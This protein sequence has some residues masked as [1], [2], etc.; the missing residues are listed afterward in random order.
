[1]DTRSKDDIKDEEYTAFYK[2]I[3]KDSKEPLKWV[4][5]KAEGE[6]EFKSILY[7]PSEATYG[8][9]EK[10]YEKAGL[11]A[12]RAKGANLGPV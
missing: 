8:E 2:S 4:H 7:I 1:M 11:E 10:Y 6:I 12:L 3:T 5:F 9:F